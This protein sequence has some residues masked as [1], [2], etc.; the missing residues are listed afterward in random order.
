MR[1]IELASLL[2]KSSMRASD[3]CVRRLLMCSTSLALPVC[4]A[5]DTGVR[6]DSSLQQLAVVWTVPSGLPR[7]LRSACSIDSLLLLSLN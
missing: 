3:M 4:L 5:Q 6:V 7:A 2:D 1:S